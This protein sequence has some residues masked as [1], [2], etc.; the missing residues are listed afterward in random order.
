ML[1][2]N[3]TPFSPMFF[4]SF[5]EHDRP[6]NVAILRGTFDLVGGGILNPAEQQTPV[7]MADE[8][9]GQPLI[10]SVRVDSDLVPRKCHADITLDAVAHAPR[11]KPEKA[12]EI[13]VTVGKLSKRLRVTGPRWWKQ[14][15][16]G[17]C[18]TDPEPCLE[19]PVRYEFAYG[20]TYRRED[21]EIRYEQNPVG[22]GFVDIDRLD[23]KT[24]VPAPQLEFL[25]E[26]IRQ[27]NRAYRPAG[28]API[29]KHCLPRRALCGTPDERW[30]FER[31]PLRPADF[32]FHYYNS[33]SAGLRYEGYFRGDEEVVLEGLSP[34][35]LL[36]FRLPGLDLLIFALN[37]AGQPILEPLHLDTLHIST[38]KMHA[39]LTW[40]ATFLK[41]E[42]LRI[43]Q[44]TVR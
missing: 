43:L 39:Y 14:G 44:F 19:V 11:G 9:N 34:K 16:L 35:G 7:V 17:W 40:R 18:L 6:I 21:K 22:R 42:T 32:D 23:R 12:W 25:D 29:A 8:Y 20:G 13:C 15:A 30:R 27:I 24:R 3:D 41:D 28:F 10:S 37:E 2:H 38:V 4:E 31:W 5:D 36:P 1:L 26:P 33:A